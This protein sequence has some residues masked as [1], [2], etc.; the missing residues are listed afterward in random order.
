MFVKRILIIY[1]I[2]NIMQYFC[3]FYLEYID[4]SMFR[5][6]YILSFKVLG[7][8]LFLIIMHIVGIRGTDL[9][10]TDL[11]DG[12][13]GQLKEDLHGKSIIYI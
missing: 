9:N 3:T 10:S 8:I 6:F 13:I 12:R 7:G 5:L 1:E 2:L 4:S 11:E